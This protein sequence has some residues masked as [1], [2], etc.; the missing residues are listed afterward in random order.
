[1]R[2]HVVVSLQG[3]LQLPVR[4]SGAGAVVRP[5]D[6]FSDYVSTADH[7]GVVHLR[8]CM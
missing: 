5:V 1:M 3:L 4:W 2:E 8:L 7:D 6:G